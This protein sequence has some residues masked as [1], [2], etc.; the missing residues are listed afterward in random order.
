[1]NWQGYITYF[2]EDSIEIFIF[3]I[4]NCTMTNLLYEKVKKSIFGVVKK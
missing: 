1:M 4:T 2:Y 3:L